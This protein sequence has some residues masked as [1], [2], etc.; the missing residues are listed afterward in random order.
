MDRQDLKDAQQFLKALFP[1]LDGNN[2]IEVRILRAGTRKSKDRHFTDDIDDA[3]VLAMG[4]SDKGYESYF[5]VSARGQ[6][7]HGKKHNLAYLSAAYADVDVGKTY[8]TKDEAQEALEDFVP[9][10][11]IIVDSGGG[12]HAYWLLNERVT[13]GEWRCR[14]VCFDCQQKRRGRCRACRI[15]MSEKNPTHIPF[16]MD[17]VEGVMRGIVQEL[18]IDNCWDATRILRVPGTENH[19]PDREPR[20]VRLLSFHPDRRFDLEALAGRYYVP[21]ADENEPAE[22]FFHDS[23]ANG[24]KALTRVLREAREVLSTG[25]LRSLKQMIK[26]G[27]AQRFKKKDDTPGD[28][29]GRDISAVKKLIRAGA[30][31]DEI[32]AIYRKYPIGDKF[33]E[34]RQGKVYLRSIIIGAEASL[35]REASG[36]T[37]KWTPPE[38]QNTY[39]WWLWR[40]CLRRLTELHNALPGTRKSISEQTGWDVRTIKKWVSLSESMGW[41]T[42]AK[43]GSTGGRPPIVYQIIH[44]NPYRFLHRMGSV[45]ALEKSQATRDLYAATNPGGLERSKLLEEVQKKKRAKL[46]EAIE[47][48]E[49]EE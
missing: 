11:S 41:V 5:G 17:R 33:S 16:A 30:S 21:R 20:P 1:V 43:D 32:L 27:G 2:R 15:C 18:E 23:A 14:E 40:I 10:P 6:K 29:S 25:E 13:F 38:H 31:R 24:K 22:G 35:A 36:E 34:P 49:R 48:E 8:K 3:A 39:Q 45:D 7:A 28:R 42:A 26:G 44:P 47:R 19:K 12:L 37:P 4:A 9:R 46:L